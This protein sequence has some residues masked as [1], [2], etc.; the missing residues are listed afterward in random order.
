M[1]VANCVYG[2]AK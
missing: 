2:S 1:K